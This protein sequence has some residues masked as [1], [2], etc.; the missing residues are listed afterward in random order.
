MAAQH[1]Q[2]FFPASF[3]ELFSS[4]ARFPDALPFAGGTAFIRN[5]GAHIPELPQGILSLDRLEELHRVTRTE[6]YLEM[7]AMVKLD[8]IIRLGKIVP[9]ALRLCLE[10]IGSPQLR[11]LATIGGN[12]CF[13][14]RRLDAASA[15]TALDAVFELRNAQST[16]WISA[17]RF[18]S[19]SGPPALNQGE[20]L[21]RI[22]VPLDQ[23]NY[24]VYRTFGNSLDAGGSFVFLMKNQKN[25]LSDIRLV[26]AGKG[27]LR[28][29]NT[30]TLLI[31]KQ[32]PLS[33]RDAEDFMDHWR[34]FLSALEDPGPFIRAEIVNFVETLILNLAD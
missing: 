10:G 16:R 17:A 13:R 32:L 34:T 29:K 12:I 9:E 7:G 15:M 1:D 8:D 27:I 18:F 22:R 33:I 30:E 20:L 24:T 25:V 5:Q 2:V 14:D 31:G 11:G 6:R 23:W 4:W 21:T 19:F 28:D 26:C 3:Q